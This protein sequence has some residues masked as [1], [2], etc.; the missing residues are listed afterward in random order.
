[1][2]HD[3]LVNITASATI[4][5]LTVKVTPEVG[6]GFT[7]KDFFFFEKCKRG[8]AWCLTVKSRN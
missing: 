6:E 5:N 2:Y 7:C 3:M 1:M 8:W 4:F